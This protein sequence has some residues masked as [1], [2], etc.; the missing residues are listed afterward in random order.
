MPKEL[1]MGMTLHACMHGVRHHPFNLVLI[2][3]ECA[4]IAGEK[5]VHPS[6]AD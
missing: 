3:M 1:Y 2:K 4:L 5:K 6:K